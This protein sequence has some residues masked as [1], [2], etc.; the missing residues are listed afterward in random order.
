VSQFTALALQPTTLALQPTTLA[1]QPTTLALQPASC[2]IRLLPDGFG[3]RL[4]LSVSSRL[5]F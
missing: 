2:F 3:C 5:F 1:L 4:T